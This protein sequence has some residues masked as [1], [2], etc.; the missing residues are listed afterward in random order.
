[1]TKLKKSEDGKLFSRVEDL[2]QEFN[3]LNEKLDSPFPESDNDRLK[4]I[5]SM[6]KEFY[7]LC[8]HVEIRGGKLQKGEK[9][10]KMFKPPLQ[11]NPLTKEILNR[12]VKQPPTP[13]KDERFRTI[14]ETFNS[15]GEILL[16]PKNNIIV[17]DPKNFCQVLV[18]DVINHEILNREEDNA[19]VG[20]LEDLER[21]LYEEDQTNP[22]ERTKLLPRG[23][24]FKRFAEDDEEEK[25]K[26]LWEL[27]EAT[28]LG[29]KL[30]EIKMFIP[31]LIS[32][33][34]KKEMEVLA[35]MFHQEEKKKMYNLVMRF[36]VQNLTDSGVEL[37]HRIS[38]GVAKNCKL[39]LSYSKDIEKRTNV[40][41]LSALIR[42]W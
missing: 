35:G 33:G 7:A 6:K 11:I 40:C 10:L 1:M 13:S 14:L 22:K 32:E 24:L 5:L 8:E 29:M 18:N 21:L 3:N 39:Q 42:D 9:S 30:S 34:C 4:I 28:Q 25:K 2:R 12:P 38:F 26:E 15:V 16:L 17:T 19:N 20:D 23:F 41:Q 37:F 31:L 36:Y 27:F